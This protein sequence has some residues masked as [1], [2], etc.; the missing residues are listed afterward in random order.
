MVPKHVL[1]SFTI[2][3]EQDDE[4]AVGTIRFILEPLNRR[5]RSRASYP[6]GTVLI[7]SSRQPFLDAARVL[8]AAGYDPKCWL[9]RG[10]P[11][12]RLSH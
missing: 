2:A 5:D 7:A 12:Q 9:E 3:I 6:D 10:E 1:G 8:I 4:P 11:E